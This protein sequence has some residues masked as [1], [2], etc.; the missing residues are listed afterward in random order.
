MPTYKFQNRE[1]A[2]KAQ[3]L[4]DQLC[5]YAGHRLKVAAIGGDQETSFE[6]AFAQ[7]AYSYISDKAPR[8]LDFL[9]GF[10]LVDRNED[11]TKAVG[12]FG[13]KT[14]N[15]W[16]YVPI[17]FINGDLKGHEL[18]YVKNKDMFLPLTEGWLNYLLSKRPFILGEG[19]SQT[20]QQLSARTPDLSGLASPPT[21]TKRGSVETPAEWPEWVTDF[22]PKLAELATKLPSEL[23]QFEGLDQRLSLDSVL[24]DDLELCKAAYSL[25]RAYPAFGEYCEKFYGRDLFK[26]ALLKLRDK[27]AAAKPDLFIHPNV[28]ATTKPVI[29][30]AADKVTITLVHSTSILARSLDDADRNKLLSTGYLVDDRRDDSETSKAY[31]TQVS[32]ALTN[33]DVTGVY[34]V[35]T[36]PGKF[37]RC[38]I[39]TSPH[40]H[41]GGRPFCTVIR[42]DGK[43]NWINEHRSNIFVRNPEEIDEPLKKWLD[44]QK[45]PESFSKGTTYVILSRTG[46]GSCPFTIRSKVDTDLY[47]VWFRDYGPSHDPWVGRPAPTTACCGA[48]SYNNDERV[49]LNGRKGTRLKA[50]RGTLYVPADAKVLAIKD[51]DSS[52]DGP[53]DISTNESKNPPVILGNAADAHLQLTGTEAELKKKASSDRLELGTVAD[54]ERVVIDHTDPLKIYHNGTEVRLNSERPWPVK[55]AFFRLIRN[56][57]FREE[58]ATELLKQAAAKRSVR[59]RVKF[60]AGYPFLPDSV[61]APSIPEQEFGFTGDLAQTVGPEEWEQQVQGQGPSAY[62]AS[63]DSSPEAMPDP[64]ALQTAMQAGSM[65]QKEVFDTAALGGLLK[66]VRHETTIDRYMGDLMKAIDRLGRVLFSFY[67][68]SDEFQDLFGKADMPELED[69]LRN[70]FEQLGEITLYLR[71]KRNVP[72][73]LSDTGPSV[74]DV[75][76]V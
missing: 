27:A 76:E 20:A 37:E 5:K 57:G 31:E 55:E 29:K 16:L 32:T 36:R 9:I 72:A 62:D 2:K 66:T 41:R 14:G 40:S 53:V 28:P 17:F 64:M 65:G 35:L 7:L 18:L 15:Q 45:E 1:L 38:L 50:L 51:S 46:H 74:E 63:Y 59:V 33:P 58:T 75:S 19:T 73:N 56:Y 21:I 61:A 39:I 25:S 12:I 34:D 10:Q 43:K 3:R 30:H 13:F 4:R 70:A 11:S 67:W 8:L 44:E 60:A 54:L 71:E 22:M 24:A 68:R 48:D 47:D 69:G 42:L 52:Y 6:Q 26:S 49:Q 23:P